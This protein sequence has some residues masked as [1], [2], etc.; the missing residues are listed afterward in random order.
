MSAHSLGSQKLFI[1]G[2]KIFLAQH[3]ETA[4][5]GNLFE[6]IVNM[7][8]AVKHSN[9]KARAWQTRILKIKQ[10]LW[11]IYSPEKEGVCL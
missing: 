4:K 8:Q 7:S 6:F 3:V 11:Y 5:K 10:I 1:L 2:E 9:T